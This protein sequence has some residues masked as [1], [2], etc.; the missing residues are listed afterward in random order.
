LCPTGAAL[1]SEQIRSRI[2]REHAE[3]KSLNSIAVALNEEAVPTAKT[4]QCYASTVA[5]VVRSVG[6]DKELGRIQERVL[7]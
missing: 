7:P 4:G 6:I 2:A 1:L 3:G 5:H